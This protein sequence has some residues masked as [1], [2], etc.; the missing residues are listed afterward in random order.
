MHKKLIKYYA[1]NPKNFLYENDYYREDRYIITEIAKLSPKILKYID[2]NLRIDD[3]FIYNLCFMIDFDILQYV[4]KELKEDYNFI[5]SLL[6]E[7]NEYIVEYLPINFR[8][9]K[10]LIKKFCKK[11]Y[12]CFIYASDNLKSDFN[13]ILKLLEIN[14]NIFFLCSN[15]II[16]NR[17]IFILTNH[18]KNKS[19]YKYKNYDYYNINFDIKNIKNFIS[20]LKNF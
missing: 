4:G 10:K 15:K 12:L 6:D 3:D 1:L 14:F 16:N 8:N 9:N 18:F 20:I 13:Y 7:S 17:S 11:N 19:C 5:Y 2:E